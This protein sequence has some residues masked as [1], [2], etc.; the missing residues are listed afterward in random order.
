MDRRICIVTG[1]RAEW[2]LLKPVARKLRQDGFDVTV[3]ATGMHLSPEFG[4]TFREIEADGFDLSE[5][6]EML[7]YPG[8]R[9]APSPSPWA[10]G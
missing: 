5:R 4:L 1:T 10:W 7:L 9:A 6:V 3:A 8:I 2:G